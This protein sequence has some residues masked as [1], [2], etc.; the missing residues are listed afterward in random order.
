M[1]LWVAL[2]VILAVTAGIL[3]VIRIRARRRTVW[4]LNDKCVIC[5]R[6]VP[7]GRMVCPECERDVMGS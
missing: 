7:E 5:G 3:L 4:P 2:A 6:Y 1:D